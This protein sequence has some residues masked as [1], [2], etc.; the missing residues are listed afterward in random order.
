MRFLA[1][2]AFALPAVLAGPMARSDNTFYLIAAHQ[3]V[4]W[5]EPSGLILG[6][7]YG[8]PNITCANSQPGDPV[9]YSLGYA[10]TGCSFT[11]Y[12]NLSCMNEV[13]F[14][15]AP[16]SPDWNGCLNLDQSGPGFRSLSVACGP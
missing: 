9:W 7:S 1:P 5:E 15:P 6:G 13:A 11:L 8:A 16:A 14:I 3:T 2:L 4:C 10:S 12:E